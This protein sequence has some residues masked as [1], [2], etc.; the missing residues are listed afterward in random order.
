MRIYDVILDSEK[1]A[2]VEFL[3]RFNLEY[4]DDIDDTN[5]YHC[6]SIECTSTSYWKLSDSPNYGTPG[7][8]NII[9]DDQY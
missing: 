9:H 4:E 1:A 6:L 2:V 5:W 8:R 7:S 3:D